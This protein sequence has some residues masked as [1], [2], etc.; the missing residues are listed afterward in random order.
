[1]TLLRHFWLDRNNTLR[2]QVFYLHCVQHP[3]GVD[4]VDWYCLC[5]ILPSVPLYT[6]KDYKCLTG[7]G[8]TEVS[9][10]VKPTLENINIFL[11]FKV[12]QP[13][14]SLTTF[15]SIWKEKLHE[16][17]VPTKELARP[18]K[19]VFIIFLY[20]LALNLLPK[21]TNS[22]D[23]WEWLLMD[24]MHF[25]MMSCAF[26]IWTWTNFYVKWNI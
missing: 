12:L 25:K 17:S 21:F 9:F 22:L 20:L 19:V 5:E 7:S 16:K 26:R 24:A 11:Q 15:D 6:E 10:T 1:M 13:G 18:K 2:F 23:R 14:I 3:F 8:G 4:P